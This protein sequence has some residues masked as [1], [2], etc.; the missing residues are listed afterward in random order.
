MQPLLTDDLLSTGVQTQVKQM[1]ASL[2]AKLG[3]KL[4]ATERNA[5]YPDGQEA[6]A[7]SI[8]DGEDVL[9]DPEGLDGLQPDADKFLTADGYDQWL[10]VLI[11]MERGSQQMTGTMKGR[12]KDDNDCPV[13][14]HNPNPLLDTGEYEVKFNDGSI[15]C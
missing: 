3:N 2:E 9:I 6:M 15:M 4:T 11:T 14:R 12:V 13:G 5:L 10:T 7:A 1:E 8:F